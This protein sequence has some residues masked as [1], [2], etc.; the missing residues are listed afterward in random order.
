MNSP[1]LFEGEH[2]VYVVPVAELGE[3]ARGREA[4]GILIDPKVWA[5][6]CLARLA[7]ALE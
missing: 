5:G 6:L 2:L 3:W 7:G 1:I 4:A